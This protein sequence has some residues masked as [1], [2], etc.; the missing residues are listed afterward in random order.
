[1]TSPMDLSSGSNVPLQQSVSPP[2][3]AGYVLVLQSGG[4]KSCV[5]VSRFGHYSV[6]A[7]IHPMD[8]TT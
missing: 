2:S 6:I 7:I 1:M 3:P 4:E 8:H 5:N